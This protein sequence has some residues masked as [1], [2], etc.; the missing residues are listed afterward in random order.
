[1]QQR[2]TGH[3]VTAGEAG[4]LPPSCLEQTAARQEER[5]KGTS[6]NKYVLWCWNLLE[7]SCHRSCASYG[8]KNRS[9]KKTRPSA[10]QDCFHGE[11]NSFSYT[12][13]CHGPGA[14][15]SQE[16]A[17]VWFLCL[18]PNTQSLHH[19]NWEL[20]SELAKCFTRC[21]VIWKTAGCKELHMNTQKQWAFMRLRSLLLSCK[22]NEQ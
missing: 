2:N 4:F 5:S 13:H 14:R 6:C 12:C 16:S 21:K 17:T 10:V 18:W 8:H 19:C 9:M 15:H 7:F 1:M 20:W 11:L 3:L 22:N